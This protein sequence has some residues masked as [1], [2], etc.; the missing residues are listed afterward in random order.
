MPRPESPG[1][2]RLMEKWN[3]LRRFIHEASML[4]GEHLTGGF[5]QMVNRI[6]TL[7]GFD[8]PYSDIMRSLHDD[9]IDTGDIRLAVGAARVKE[10]MGD[11]WISP[12]REG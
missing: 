11:E 1:R 12:K 8:I 10:Q 5:G 3:I 7:R 2:L 9:G 6:L 4:P